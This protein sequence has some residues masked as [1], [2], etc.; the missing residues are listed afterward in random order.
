M[1]TPKEA[2]SPHGQKQTGE[3]GETGV[4]LLNNE[5]FIKAVFTSIPEHA[6]VVVCAKTGDPSEGGWLAASASEFAEHLSKE[7]NNYVGCSGFYPLD[8][9]KLVARK[10]QF[11]ACHFL[12]LD[13]LG[14][15]V[16]FEG[17]KGFEPSWLIETSPGNFQGGI[18]FS[19][20]L[21]DSNLASQLLDA[22]IRSGFC[23]AGS[24][25]PSTR[26]ARLPV[27]INGKP[28]YVQP[29][30]SPF[31]CQLTK[32]DPTKRYSPAELIDLLGL[33]LAPPVH[34]PG[35]AAN[36]SP[37]PNNT[38]DAD[39]V[40][41][42][43]GSENAVIT[44]LKSK[45]LYKSRLDE[46]K[47][48]ITCPWVHEHT[49]QQDTGTAY[50]EPS[51]K[52]PRGGFCCQHSHRDTYKLKN[53]LD[54]L[55]IHKSIA[56]NKPIIRLV[57]G[58]LN[59][60]VDAAE[61]VLAG[62]HQHYQFGGFIASI[63]IDPVT[64]DS[65][66][67]L[68]SK[69][70]LTLTLSNAAAW[71]KPARE[72]GEWKSCDPPVRHIN[73]LHQAQQFKHLP[74]LAG[75]VRQPYFRQHDGEL[76]TKA[77]Y[78]ETSKLYAHF[79]SNE[80]VIRDLTIDEARAQLAILENL[81]GEF[82]F[83]T[84]ADKAAAISAIFT[85]VVR[86][87]LPLAPAFH[88]QAPVPG[89]GKTYLCEL[90]GAFAGPGGN[91]KVSY[92]TSSEEA[93]KV[94]LSLL[95]TNPAV[96]EFDDMDTDW[97]PHGTIKR[98]LTAERITDRILGASKTA[99]VSTRTLFLGSGNNVGPVR[100]LLRRVLTVHIDPRCATPATM[101]YKASPVEE[102]RKNRG[103]YVA[104]VL[105]IIQAWRK[106]GS[107]KTDVANIVTFNGP[108]SEYCRQPLLWLGL[109]DPATSLL[110]QIRHDPE[111]DELGQLLIAWHST[112]GSTPTTVRKLLETSRSN[113]D[114]LE[115]LRE[116]PIEEKGEINRRKLGHFLKR[117]ANRI[118]D[119][120]ELQKTSADGRTAWC[121]CKS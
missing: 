9:G 73:I 21:T 29:D 36:R 111:G 83:V 4:T 43:Q 33:E 15:K 82:H 35:A 17:L 102:V 2:I 108:W 53:L 46:I 7:N 120:Y 110:N 42:L 76:V 27:A 20:P 93:T 24:T 41:I 109:S 116:F 52:F 49:D 10:T 84:P 60:I 81:L 114:L 47:H 40:L 95:L 112:F 57:S 23:D 106:A 37:S 34:V 16:P 98:M 3:T 67:A 38:L 58:G 87:S 118:V 48:D 13:D 99:T 62:T 55:G 97:I 56:R 5:E 113:P 105:G 19:E 32:W 121:V 77:G 6:C 74:T 14:T 103:L 45:G 117:N 26:W 1:T 101:Q 30:G 66:I 70:A 80:F 11:A 39:D 50:F 94:I 78:D 91:A 51:E 79:D 115:N 65:S 89:S 86:A 107:P 71:E 31:R 72:V 85:S 59:R 75:V 22:L 96:I 68:T 88:I 8:S 25:N 28:K 18:I 119:G 64:G 61:K 92:P 12:M 90:I 54:H 104:I 44:S 100:D 69:E 63:A